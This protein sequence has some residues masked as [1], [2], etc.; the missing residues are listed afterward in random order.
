MGNRRSTHTDE[1]GGSQ[2]TVGPA[3]PARAGAR[4]S[5]AWPWA[6]AGMLLFSTALERDG[7]GADP[8]SLEARLPG[9]APPAG[10]A[11]PLD[12]LPLRELRRLPGIGPARALAIVRARWELGLRG[13]P[14]AWDRVPGVGEGTVA[15][16]VE[17]SETR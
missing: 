12:L 5:P 9:P 4:R 13:A 2:D 16:L 14:Q 1:A 15:G 11:A 8:R 7:P 3:G 10:S 17:W 6:C